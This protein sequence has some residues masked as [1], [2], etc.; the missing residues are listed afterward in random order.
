MIF[1][2]LVAANRVSGVGNRGP[3]IPDTGHTNIRVGQSQGGAAHGNHRV[4]QCPHVGVVLET[5]TNV[6]TSVPR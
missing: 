6:G 4:L 2:R 5:D 1:I 3:P